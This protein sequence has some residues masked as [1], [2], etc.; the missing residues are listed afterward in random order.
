MLPSVLDPA[1]R[2]TLAVLLPG[3]YHD[4]KSKDEVQARDAKR[5]A[6]DPNADLALLRIG[7][8]PMPALAIRESETV[9][10]GQDVFFTGFPIGAV[11]GPFPAT[12]RGMV[13]AV[14]PIAIPQGRASELDPAVVRRLSTGSFTVFQLDATA[15]PGNSG[16]P[17]YDPDTG[18]VI[19]IVNMVLVRSTKESALTQPSGI[20]Y[21]VPAKYLKGLIRRRADVKAVAFVPRSRSAAMDDPFHW[22]P[23]LKALILPPAAPLIVAFLGLAL[24]ARRPRAGRALTLAGL[25]LLAAL[26]TPI[27]A[28]MLVRA[29]DQTPPL[30]RTLAMGAQAIVILGGGIRRRAPEYGGDT[31]SRLTLER[32]R[33]GAQCRYASPA[34]RC[35]CREAASSAEDAT[36]AAIMK[37]A[38]QD[39]FGV[40]VR[41]AEDRSRN[42]NE[43]AR[44]S[45]ALLRA[46]GVVALSSSSRTGSTCRV[47]RPSSPTAGIVTI[48]APTGIPV[49][50]RELVLLDFVPNA[51][52]LQTSYYA[53]YENVRRRAPLLRRRI[54]KAA[55]AAAPR[56]HREVVAASV[57]RTAVNEAEAAGSFPLRREVS[58]CA[59]ART[60]CAARWSR[61]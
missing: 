43:N 11:L 48:P 57:E 6:V 19:G 51:A 29:V 52:A 17:V 56:R 4:A 61:R 34:F 41:W 10:E 42:T 13:S 12:H 32:V 47:R 45:A 9:R 59:S 37:Q 15:Y 14:T 36:E 60:R 22:K 33:Y 26:S 38:M 25:V 46:D 35:W 30:D 28:V 8:A 5:I 44:M 58:A 18:E 16:S 2:E 21:A 55:E 39:E 49:E 24:M 1:R 7:G 23:L 20:T 50:Q 31:M 53:L 54:G 3:K 40:A 27:V